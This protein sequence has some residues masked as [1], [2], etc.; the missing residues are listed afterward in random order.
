[1][2]LNYKPNCRAEIPDQTIDTMQHTTCRCHGYQTRH[3]MLHNSNTY[4]LSSARGKIPPIGV[5]YFTKFTSTIN[6]TAERKS[7]IK[8]QLI[9][10][11]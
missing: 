9:G 5:Q 4:N 6:E 7:S 3:P 8:N 2:T 1:M 11:Q 10:S